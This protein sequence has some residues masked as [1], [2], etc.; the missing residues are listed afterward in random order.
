[1]MPSIK[2]WRRLGLGFLGLL[3]LVGLAGFTF[4][5]TLGR[6]L[7][8]H[9][10]EVYIG[11]HPPFLNG[12]FSVKTQMVEMRDGT[13]LATHI[14]TPKGPGPWPTLLVRDAYQFNKYL[15]CYYYVRYNYACVHQDVR[16][17]G[18]SE[19]EWY[20]LKHET[21]DGT[22]TLDWLTKQ[23]FQNGKIALV[24]G[25]YLGLVQ[26]AVADRLP[27][28]VKTIVPI[29][30]HGDFYDMVY[31]GGHFTQGIAGLW[32]AEIFHPLKDK[33]KAASQWLETVVPVRPAEDAP[34]ELFKG[35]WPSYADYI[36]HPDRQDAYWH[37]P[38]YE[39]IER[40]YRSVSV[41]VLWIARWHDFFLQGT[42]ARFDELP[43]RDSS[44]L[45]IRPGQH[46][47]VT[48]DLN[49]ANPDF[50][51]FETTLAWFDH[52]LKGTP[53][54]A[55]LQNR[56]IYYENGADSWKMGDT[57]PAAD[58][59]P[60]H[61]N[62]DNLSE[63]PTCGGTL[64]ASPVT[65]ADEAH[66]TYDPGN[67]VPTNGGA[68][69]LNPN[70]A[71]SAVSEQGTSACARDDVLTFQ[72]EAFEDGLHLSGPLSVDL[73]VQTDAPETAFTVKVSEAFADG[74]V[75]NIRDSLA[76]FTPSGTGAGSLTIDLTPIDWVLSEGSKLRLDISSSNYPAFPAHPNTGGI[77][78]EVA[79]PKVARQTLRGGTVTLTVSA[80]SEAVSGP[81]H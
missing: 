12:G 27:G 35:A 55:P 34:R 71:P 8:Y 53:L 36:H 5:E 33:E 30:A 69:L 50:P 41:P 78:S 66:Y 7:V 70:I 22:D 13:H 6:M 14:Y 49:Y 40:S 62:L 43:T 9:F 21:D 17:Q 18:D 67:P 28:E 52:Y 26:W 16:G 46:T 54:P 24:G 11:E 42:L 80:D 56:V 74:R 65:T 15:T 76:T 68:F 81:A 64:V 48:G 19:G 39:Q 38:F 51:E 60:L 44:L 72:S 4:R 20:P 31:H 73:D 77:W 59:R 58:V 29:T 2:T 63:S 1:M 25:S 47:G 79:T 45:L 3:L 10:T 57:W 32:S 61:L 75:W 23:D 37:Q